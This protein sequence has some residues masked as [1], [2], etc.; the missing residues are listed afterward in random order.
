MVSTKGGS[1]VIKLLCA[2]VEEL[3]GSLAYLSSGKKAEPKK[4][5]GATKKQIAIKV[6]REGA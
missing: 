2:G 5:R 4:V 3:A 1:P 6:A